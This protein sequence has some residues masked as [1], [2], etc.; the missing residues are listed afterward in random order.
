MKSLSKTK[1]VCTIGPACESQEILRDMMGSGMRVARLNFSHGSPDTHNTIYQRLRQVAQELDIPLCIFQDLSGPKLRIGKFQKEKVFIK[2][3]DSFIL[4]GEPVLGD[5]SKVHVDL[6]CVA[7]Q[8]Q[9]G[10]RVLLADGLIELKIQS[11]ELP[12]I[13]TEVQVGGWLS[14]RKGISF[15]GRCL[16]LEALTEKDRE[17]LKIGLQLGVD[18]VALSFVRNHKNVL[19]LQKLIKEAGS[20]SKVIAKLERME[21]LEDLDAILDVSDGVMVAR[22]DLGIDLAPEKVPLVQKQIIRE[23]QRRDVYVITATQMLESMIHHPWPTRAE[24]SDVANAVLDGTDAIMLS[25]E[26][27]M[28]KY[29][30]RAVE[31]MRRIACETES[32]HGEG[33]RRRS[34]IS[35]HRSSFAGSI[36]WAA[37]NIAQ[38]TKAR[39]ICAYTHSGATAR[40]I[41]KAHPEVDIIGLTPNPEVLTQLNLAWGVTPILVSPA[42]GLDEMIDEVEKVVLKHSLAENGDTILIVAGYPLEQ[43]GLTNLVKVHK[44]GGPDPN[45]W[46]SFE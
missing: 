36:S 4:T 2:P 22:G 29:P 11:V 26:T 15:P 27:A 40:L 16:P 19:E 45:E 46:Q 32:V 6:D 17:D 23:A 33:H 1:I 28:G 24:T 10:Q 35:L 21:A 34:D 18:Y 14:D 37:G 30:V 38:M 41:S 42:P 20:Q 12:N 9:V 44:I 31:M 8:I 5:E 7:D 43:P 39:A 3:G 13:V 25:G